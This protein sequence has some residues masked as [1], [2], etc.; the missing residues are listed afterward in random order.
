MGF[1]QHLSESGNECI[2][3]QRDGWMDGCM[4]KCIN[5]WMDGWM[6]GWTV[7]AGWLPKG[8]WMDGWMDGW[9]GGKMHAWMGGWLY[10]QRRVR[11][12]VCCLPTCLRLAPLV[13]LHFAVMRLPI[14]SAVERMPHVVDNIQPIIEV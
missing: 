1:N 13:D 5:G 10:E 4:E 2:K 3:I 8:G 6:G 7:S 11:N 14:F 9:M 12:N